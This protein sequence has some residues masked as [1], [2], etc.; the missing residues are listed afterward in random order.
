MICFA[1][2]LQARELCLFTRTSSLYRL[3]ILF[4]YKFFSVAD[5][6]TVAVAVAIITFVFSFDFAV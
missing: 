3:N 1:L 5:A 6:V 4:I 2:S